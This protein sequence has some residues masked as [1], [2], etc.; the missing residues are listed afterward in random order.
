MHAVSH[1]DVRKWIAGVSGHP[2]SVRLVHHVFRMI[3]ELAVR[4]KR[5]PSNPATG[6]RLP[7]AIKPEKRFLTVDELHRLADCAA[8]YPHPLVGEQYR[9][10]ILMLGYTGLRWGEVAALRVKRV[11]LLR[12][13]L[14]IAENVVEVNGHNLAR[15]DR[16]K[17]NGVVS[18]D[19][20]TVARHQFVALANHLHGCA[21]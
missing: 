16:R 1:A 10:L 4:D 3:L 9:V 8:Q 2:A 6:V 21:A 18:G 13:R 12:R 11:D 14:T 15:Y 17:V 7:R 5:I 19:P 20:A